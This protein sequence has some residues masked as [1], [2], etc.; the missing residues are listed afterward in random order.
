MLR[1]FFAGLCFF[2]LSACTADPVLDL[3]QLE[4]SARGGDRQAIVQ[5]V[6]L[7]S[8]REPGL[9]DRVY[10]ITI[11]IGEKTVPAL[12]DQVHSKDKQLREYVI[13]A[14]GTL[15]VVAAIPAISDVLAQ[16]ALERR[17][18]AAWALGAIG[19]VTGS[20]CLLTAGLLGFAAFPVICCCSG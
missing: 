3:D 8:A 16:K 5:L 9:A 2:I 18:V 13:A 4:A 11:E 12:L 17:Y 10:T 19:R 15:K 6:G 1:Y 20:A 7:L 14:L